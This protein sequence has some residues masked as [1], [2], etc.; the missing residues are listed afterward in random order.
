MLMLQSDTDA[1]QAELV[2]WR[3]SLMLLLLVIRDHC[4][5]P[6]YNTL[7]TLPCFSWLLPSYLC[8]LAQLCI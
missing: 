7:L 1:N 6:G 3:C 2:V 8:T 5:E 4:S